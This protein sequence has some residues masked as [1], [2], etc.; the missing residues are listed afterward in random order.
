[1]S[2]RF[3]QCKNLLKKV[4]LR[5]SNGSDEFIRFF[6]KKGIKIGD[7]CRIY[8]NILTSEPYLIEIGN[9]VT[10]STEVLLLNH[11][12]SISKIFPEYTD[13]FGKIVIGDNCFIG[14][15]SIIL[16]GV[17]LSDNI[18]V[19]AGSLVTKSYEEPGIIIGGNPAKK[20]NSIGNVK[21]RFIK[22][23]SNIRF[24][25]YEDK[26]RYILNEINLLEK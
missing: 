12:N 3:I 9:N 19:G 15:R 10:I 11:D 2:Y 8:S 24:M 13:M 14:A 25:S 4:I 20:N 21:E 23:G 22:Y 7:N 16:P 18:I 1:M 26:R 17:H 6:R 5:N